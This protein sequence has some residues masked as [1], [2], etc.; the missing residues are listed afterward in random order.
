MDAI[1]EKK[2]IKKLNKIFIL[3][4]PIIAII[5]FVGSFIFIK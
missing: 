5:C 3:L 4:N 1:Q 2:L